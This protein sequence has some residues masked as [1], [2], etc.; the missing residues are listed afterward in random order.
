MLQKFDTIKNITAENIMTKNPVKKEKN[1][2]ASE[3]RKL[4]SKK[5][6]N[7]IVVINKNKKYIGIVHILD[8]IK[9]GF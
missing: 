2:L 3:A 5:K 4:M 9:E 1:F 7:H 6:I 8:L